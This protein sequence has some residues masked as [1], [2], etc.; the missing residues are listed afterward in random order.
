MFSER[1]KKKKKEKTQSKY[2]PLQTNK[3]RNENRERDRGTGFLAP[4]LPIRWANAGVLSV[5]RLYFLAN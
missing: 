5:L 3:Q 2:D 1:G 4:D